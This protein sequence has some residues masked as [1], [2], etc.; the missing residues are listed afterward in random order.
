[1]HGPALIAPL[2][3]A[4]A[5]LAAQP[6]SAFEIGSRRIEVSGALDTK[7]GLKLATDL[8]KLDESDHGPIYLLMT[9]SGGSAQGVMLAADTIKSI[10]S[11][12]VAVV[13]AP[14]Q[15]A[16]ATLPVF[17]DRVV[18]LP[19]AALVLTEVDY[20]GVAKPP[21]PKPAKPPTPEDKPEDKKEPT[22]AELFLQKVRADYLDRFWAAVAKR[23]GDKPA[24]LAADIAAGGRVITAQDALAKKIAFEV[25]SS[26]ATARAPTVKTEIK[27]TTTK[28]KST[29]VP[30]AAP[31]TN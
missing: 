29:V 7:A 27:S 24:T 9:G 14:L 20:E 13:L 1:M 12:V 6:V 23:T 8:L 10:E 2:A 17:C 11:P 26:L 19:N 30:D 25:V 22:K 5:V 4:L 31:G 3:L 18:M 16:Q 15:G 28:S 21:E